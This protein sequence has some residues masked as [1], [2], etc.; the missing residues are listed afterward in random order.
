VP[1]HF[2]KLRREDI[3]PVVDKIIKIILGWKGKLLSFGAGL[4]LL[5]ACF[6]SIPIYLMSVIRF[7]KWAIESINSQMTNFF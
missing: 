1:L 7:P 2:D 3:Q 4:A 6:V 5:K